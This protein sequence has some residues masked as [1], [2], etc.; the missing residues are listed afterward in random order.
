MSSLAPPSTLG[1]IV[2]QLFDRALMKKLLDRRRRRP[3]GDVFRENEHGARVLHDKGRGGTW[4][5]A[6]GTGA[7][8]AFQP[9]ARFDASAAFR[10]REAKEVGRMHPNNVTR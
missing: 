5:A 4:P 3:G 10:T 6:S 2:R 7:G 8:L 9:Y 1:R